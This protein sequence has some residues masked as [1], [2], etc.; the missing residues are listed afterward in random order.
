MLPG[1]GK[2]SVLWPLEDGGVLRLLANCGDE[3]L[4]LGIPPR[5]RLL[6]GRDNG[7]ILDGWSVSW[8]LE[9]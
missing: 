6:W 3:A 1:S 5:G 7:K 4:E 9:E 2:I 8:W